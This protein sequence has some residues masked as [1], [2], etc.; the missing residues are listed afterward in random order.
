MQQERNELVALRACNDDLLAEV[1]ALQKDAR[2]KDFLL[3]A[4]KAAAAA[5]ADKASACIQDLRE[6]VVL[7]CL[8]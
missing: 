4:Q 6:Q 5:A 3:A 2:A 1:R 8:P 7:V